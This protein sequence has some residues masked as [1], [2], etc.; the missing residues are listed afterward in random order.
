MNKVNLHLNIANLLMESIAGTALE[1]SDKKEKTN[2]PW[3][4]QPPEHSKESVIRRCVQVRQ[5]LLMV[6]KELRKM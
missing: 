4:N 5:E 3:I 6:M 2:A 1:W